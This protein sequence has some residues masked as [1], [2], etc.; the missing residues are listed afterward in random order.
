MKTGKKTRKGHKS[1]TKDR[2]RQNNLMKRFVRD[3]E[4]E[5][6]LDSETLKIILM[7]N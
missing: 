5:E 3:I 1:I 7:A 2:I 4:R 6:F